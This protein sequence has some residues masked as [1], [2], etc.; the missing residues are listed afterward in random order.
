V[1][2]IRTTGKKKKAPPPALNRQDEDLEN[3]GRG[4]RRDPKKGDRRSKT[5]GSCKARKER[6]L[7][8]G[9]R[10]HQVAPEIAALEENHPTWSTFYKTQQKRLHPRWSRRKEEC[11]TGWGEEGNPSRL[12]SETVSNTR[13][14]EEEKERA[15]R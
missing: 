4:C 3:D 5:K 7:F 1:L 15:I 12:R 6:G 9:G 8:S 2:S 11:L 13:L 14:E 10:Y